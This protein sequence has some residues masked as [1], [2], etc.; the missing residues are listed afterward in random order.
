MSHP[1]KVET[2]YQ[3]SDSSV[4]LPGGNSL[5]QH[6]QRR[7]SVVRVIATT[8]SSTAAAKAA[9]STSSSKPST[10]SSS[11]WSTAAATSSSF[12][13]RCTTT[14]T[15][16][17]S[18][19]IS[20]RTATTAVSSPST[21]ATRWSSSSG[22]FRHAGLVDALVRHFEIA[23]LKLRSIQLDGIFD[24]LIRLHVQERVCWYI[25]KT[26]KRKGRERMRIHPETTKEHKCELQKQTI[27]G[28]LECIQ[29][30]HGKIMNLLGLIK[31]NSVGLPAV[32]EI[33]DKQNLW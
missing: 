13:A 22:H 2:I 11:T 17:T 27:I 33:R 31:I 1:C 4:A 3:T 25:G 29:K 23:T 12:I 26:R 24:R 30:S 18:F 15:T 21:A 8:T 10:V 5:S 28:T 32:P 6:Q 19:P 16:T 20:T 9:A 14:T 7:L